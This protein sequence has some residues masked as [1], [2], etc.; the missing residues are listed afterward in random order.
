MLGAAVSTAATQQATANAK[1]AGEEVKQG[2][3]NGTNGDKKKVSSKAAKLLGMNS[4][5][6][7]RFL[8]A[9]QRDR[10]ERPPGRPPPNLRR[11]ALAL[12]PAPALIQLRLFLADKRHYPFAGTA[13]AAWAMDAQHDG[14]TLSRAREAAVAAW[15]MPAAS[16]MRT[17][18]VVAALCQNIGTDPPDVIKTGPVARLE[19]W[20]DPFASPPAKAIEKIAAELQRQ[21]ERWQARA[22]YKVLQDPT[23]DQ[24]K[25]TCMQHRRRA[26]GERVLFHY[27]G[28]GVPRPTPNGEIWVFNRNFTQYIPLS[29]YDL[30]SWPVPISISLAEIIIFN[31]AHSTLL[32][33]AA[34]HSS[35]LEIPGNSLSRGLFD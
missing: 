27:N 7:R 35:D 23:F 3:G 34:F 10:A 30:Q 2:P 19:C 18:C 6:E 29:V 15:R 32:V 26:R 8:A 13:V 1:D 12:P 9:Q 24:V 4:N 11:G 16:R 31:P 21:Y 33:W 22:Q 14:A 17:M 25:K 20:T 28:H 5:D